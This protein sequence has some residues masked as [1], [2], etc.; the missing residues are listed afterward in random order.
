MERERN[1]QQ[2]SLL[3]WTLVAAL[4]SQN[5]LI[6]VKS[7]ISADDQKNYYSPD[8]HT[9]TPPSRSHGSPPHGG[10]GSY[11]S[12]PPSHGTPSH[13]GG[14]YGSTP[15]SHGGG[16]S[17]GGTPP[18][19]CGNPP[20]G[21][22]Y[23]PTPAPPTSGGGGYYNSPPT[24][25][26]GTPPTPI[27]ETPPTPIIET[28]PTPIIETPP[29]TPIIDPG[30]PTIPSPPFVYD[31]NSP[32]FTC[33]YWR[34]HPGLIW[35]VLGFWGT[36]GGAFGTASVP[37]FGSNLSLKQA[38]LNARTDGFGA[39]YR[40]GTASLLN[41]MVDTKFPLTT[42]QVRDNFMAAIGSNKAA[43]TQARLFK[44]ANEGRLKPRT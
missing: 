44:L 28:P 4:L 2:T 10:G 31:P 12:T 29:T 16:G 21:G 39:L 34:T 27:I 20:S 19:N 13:G 32:P 11:G 33:N 3:M 37:G 43:A 8:P 23:D 7:I 9:G 18:S 26:G 22:H 42:K 25:G 30:T 6:P 36:V 41:S 35:S 38:L 15:P 14:S 17:Y 40:E 24:Y 5:L 1:I